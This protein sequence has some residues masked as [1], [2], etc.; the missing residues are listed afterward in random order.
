MEATRP[1]F[2][3]RTSTGEGVVDTSNLGLMFPEAPSHRPVVSEVNQSEATDPVGDVIANFTTPIITTS[4]NTDRH[5]SS[6]VTT[7]PSVP[8]STHHMSTTT[9]SITSTANI[10]STT[11]GNHNSSKSLN[12]LYTSNDP[13]TNSDRTILHKYPTL[14]DTTI[15]ATTSIEHKG[16]SMTKEKHQTSS[17]DDVN[18]TTAATVQPRSDEQN[19][20]DQ[21]A[22]IQQLREE[23]QQ[24]QNE[25]LRLR[26]HQQESGSTTPTVS[27]SS[28]LQTQTNTAWSQS[29][30]QPQQSL[31][32]STTTQ[33]QQEYVTWNNATLSSPPQ[34]LKYVC[35]GNCRTWLRAPRNALMVYCPTCQVVNNCREHTSTT[36]TTT[37]TNTDL[38]HR[39]SSN[40][41]SNTNYRE[42]NPH[43]PVS[44]T[45]SDVSNQPIGYGYGFHGWRSGTLDP[46]I[47]MMGVFSTYINDCLAGIGTQLNLTGKRCH[48]HCPLHVTTL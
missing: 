7:S 20:S 6:S 8:T 24:L 19:I 32:S 31:L 10:S 29:Q 36:T 47:G 5:P 40:V 27:S 41:Y 18:D 34:E 30:S 15:S 35:C 39:S 43:H 1:S 12:L 21:D 25:V 16:N 44:N 45:N 37:T 28:S 46:L 4:L 38:G 17:N 3:T 14:P 2:T 13:L 26:H 48:S 33:Q 22:L 9:A 23:N 42:S 11:S